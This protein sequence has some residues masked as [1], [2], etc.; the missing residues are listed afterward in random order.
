MQVLLAPGAT[1]K[2]FSVGSVDEID[3]GCSKIKMANN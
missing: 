2:I 1:M 3:D